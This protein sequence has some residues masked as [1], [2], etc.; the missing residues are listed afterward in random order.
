MFNDR[1]EEML[2]QI[3]GDMLGIENDELSCL[4]NA[5][6]TTTWIIIIPH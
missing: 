4:E 1:L 5:F 6:L 3:L 2:A